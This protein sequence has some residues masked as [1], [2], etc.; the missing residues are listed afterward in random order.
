MTPSELSSQYGLMWS[1]D[2]E[3]HTHRA[4]LAFGDAGQIIAVIPEDRLVIAIGSVPTDE[5]GAIDG[6]IVTAFCV[7]TDRVVASGHRR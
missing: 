6:G 3:S 2:I 5:T 7:S 4:W 1:L